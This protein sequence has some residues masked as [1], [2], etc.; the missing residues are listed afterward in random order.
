MEVKAHAAP[1]GPGPFGASARRP[2]RRCSGP[3]LRGVRDHY[4]DIGIVSH[5]LG[6]YGQGE[7]VL[8]VPDE[9]PHPRLGIRVAQAVGAAAL[10]ERGM[11]GARERGAE[12]VAAAD[13]VAGDVADAAVDGALGTVET[14]RLEALGEPVRQ[15]DLANEAALADHGVD[16]AVPAGELNALGGGAG[17]PRLGAAVGRGLFVAAAKG[18]QLRARMPLACTISVASALRSACRAATRRTCDGE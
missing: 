7:P 18:E 2:T 6:D 12:R 3:R 13:V 16:H 10:P 11:A 9:L 4:A 14:A 8:G 17:E 1:A 15:Q 5:L